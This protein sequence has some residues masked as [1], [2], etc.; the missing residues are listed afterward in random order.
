MNF[1]P[2]ANIFPLLQGD[3]FEALKADISQNG[4]IEPIWLHPD[5]RIVDGRNRWLACDS[6]AIAPRFKTWDGKG[7]LVAFVVSLNLHRRHLTS[8][9]RA[10]VAVDLLPILED[11]A[12]D[13]QRVNGLNNSPFVDP[14]NSQIIDDSSKGRSTDKAAEILNTNRQ[15]VSDAKKLAAESPALFEQVKAGELTIPQAK[16][17]SQP[18]Q[19][20]LSHETVEYYTPAK[21][22]EAARTVMGGID[23]D[24][25]SCEDAQ[26]T[27]KASVFYSELDDGLSQEWLGRIWCN[28][29]YSKTAG[30]SNQ[31]L[32]AN[33]L[34]NEHKAGNVTEA[35]ILV[36][37]ALGYKWF[38]DLWD[39]LPACLVRERLSFTK[40]DGN[41][42]GESKHGTT[43]FYLGPNLEKFI[44]VFSL[45]GRITSPDGRYIPQRS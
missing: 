6:L 35:H 20:M 24:P 21:I 33:R 8:S 2:A 41:T 16:A 4:L 40:S 7:S 23:L 11:E 44:E 32:W 37:S 15:Y 12:K 29:P 27:V 25:A 3:E 14:S 13:R 17:M 31:E 39:R 43:I 5:G 9:Q 45:F 26:R 28:P 18:M 22:I 42:D 19:V 10:A 1:H 36:K 30:R 34:L 38:E